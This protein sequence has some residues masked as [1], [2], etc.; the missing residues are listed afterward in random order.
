MAGQNDLLVGGLEKMSLYKELMCVPG[1]SATEKDVF[2]V[3]P[4]AR[5]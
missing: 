2:H 1:S 4:A 3:L 5:L